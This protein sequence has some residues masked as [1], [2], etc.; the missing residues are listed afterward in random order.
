MKSISTLTLL[1]RLTIA[2][3]ATLNP[4]T[5]AT[6]LTLETQPYAP[7]IDPANFI[8]GVTN[9]YFPLTP[10]TTLVYEGKTEKGLERSEARVSSETKVIMGVICMTVMD[11]VTVDGKLEEATLDWYAQDKQG[12][13]WY[14]GEA[15]K[16]YENGKVVSTKGSWIGGVNGAKP[17]YIMKAKPSVGETYRQEYYK[18][19]AE[20]VANVLS[21]NEAVTVPYGSYKNVWV[22]KEWSLL[23]TPP[24]YENKY[25][26]K[27]IGT[28]MV[29]GGTG[30]GWKLSLVEIRRE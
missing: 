18:G 26:A 15:S 3:A 6:P 30:K 20:D 28:V 5:L 1:V 17:G 9:P 19:E 16:A 11:T 22:N 10:G 8:A 21:L 2:V 27:G 23:E 12:N 13:V 29:T 14:F 24:S 25:Y 7:V 4:I